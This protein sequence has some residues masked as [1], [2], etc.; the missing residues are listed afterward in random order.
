RRQ[1]R[2]PRDLR[3]DGGRRRREARREHAR[4][5]V[6]RR[7]RETRLHARSPSGPRGSTRPDRRRR[8]TVRAPRRRA[9]RRGARARP[10]SGAR[11]GVPRRYHAAP[12]F[13]PVRSLSM[14]FLL[15]AG[16]ASALVALLPQPFAVLRALQAPPAAPA[17]A[18]PQ[19]APVALRKWEHE[20][21]DLKVNARI[22]FGALPNGLRY[23]WMDNA[24]PKH[25]V[26]LRM[27][28]NAGSLGEEESER[29]MAH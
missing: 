28:V 11:R 22:H 6:A 18:A 27:H 17:Q 14:S 24:E 8:G 26:F 21:S 29:G 1:R 5:V 2:D 10:L 3:R 13:P 9:P 12:A 15:R 20:S 16:V 25:R 23:A 7:V 4:R 19:T